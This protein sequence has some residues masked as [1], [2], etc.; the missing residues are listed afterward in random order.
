MA[1]PYQTS[2]SQASAQSPEERACAAVVERAR[3]DLPKSAFEMWFAGLAPGKIRGEVVELVAPSSYVRSWLSGHYMDLI[4]ASVG[5][6][7]G[8]SARVRLR[9]ADQ[10]SW[11]SR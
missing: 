7:L 9:T 1:I 10:R 5:S 8:P 4:H 2:G 11:R 6:V 3:H